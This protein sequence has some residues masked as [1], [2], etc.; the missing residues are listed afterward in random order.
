MKV[1][2]KPLIVGGFT[3]GEYSAYTEIEEELLA[4]E[5]KIRVLPAQYFYEKG[6]HFYLVNR[7]EPGENKFFPNGGFE[8][9]SEFGQK[10][11]YDLDQ[12]IIHPSII[13]HKKTLEKMVR[14]AEKET[15]KRDRRLKR[16]E[17]K[18]AKKYG[19]RGRPALSDEDRALRELNKQARAKISGGKR[20]RPTSTTPKVKVM[21]VA[22]GGKRGRPALSPE[23]KLLR[24]QEKL[25]T[26]K[27]TG[28]KRGRPASGKPKVVKVKS[29]RGRGRPPKS[30]YS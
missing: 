9:R 17:K 29:G 24:E 27:R 7:Y 21:A 22:G 19:K 6:L 11:S 30:Q 16:I 12:V 23:Q 5:P 18:T 28:G 4:F 8:V 14:R 15:A 25:A 3:I 10:H 20:G 2:K 13:K 26:A 1:I